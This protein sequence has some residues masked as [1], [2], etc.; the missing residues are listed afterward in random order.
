MCVCE[1]P[2]VSREQSGFDRQRLASPLTFPPPDNMSEIQPDV[3]SAVLL[4]PPQQQLPSEES[5]TFC[6]RRVA[7]RGGF[8]PVRVSAVRGSAAMANKGTAPPRAPLSGIRAASTRQDARRGGG[9][10]WT[11]AARVAP[12]PGR[13]FKTG[14]PGHI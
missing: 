1:K 11:V 9:N 12:A 13:A 4:P 14:A 2:A 3:P 6:A 5:P 10:A 8:S 7:F